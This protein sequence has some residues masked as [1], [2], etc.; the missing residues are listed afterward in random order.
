MLNEPLKIMPLELD[1]KDSMMA[2]KVS[3]L[4]LME[5]LLLVSQVM[6]VFDLME[7]MEQFIVISLIQINLLRE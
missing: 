7:I 6:V 1:F 5:L 4:V 2:P 3:I